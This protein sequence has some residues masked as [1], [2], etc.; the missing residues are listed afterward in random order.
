M[1]VFCGDDDYYTRIA[2]LGAVAY[3]TAGEWEMVV[4]SIHCH[5][6]VFNVM[7]SIHCHMAF[8]LMQCGNFKVSWLIIIFLS[9]DNRIVTLWF[10]FHMIMRP[11]RF[12]KYVDI[13]MC[14][15][16]QIIPEFIKLSYGE[17]RSYFYNLWFLSSVVAWSI[18]FIGLWQVLAAWKGFLLELFI[19]SSWFFSH[20]TTPN[21]Q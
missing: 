17:D 6:I 19:I 8:F 21:P 20:P 10:P 18:T 5:V 1:F 13:T 15:L 9:R 2:S 12:L 11:R 16:F 3:L 4:W 7:W 14:F